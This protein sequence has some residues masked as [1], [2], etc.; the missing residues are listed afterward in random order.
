VLGLVRPVQE[1][2]PVLLI[3]SDTLPLLGFTVAE[4]VV[5]PFTVTLA[6]VV[7]G[8]DVAPVLERGGLNV[9]V[10]VR[11]LQV[12]VPVSCTGAFL[13]EAVLTPIEATTR[14]GRISAIAPRAI[15]DFF[16]SPP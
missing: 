4:P 3:V 10:P 16:T 15:I 12:S 1:F 2:P 7:S 6:V 5:H 9:S 13:A 14:M 8:P 11:V